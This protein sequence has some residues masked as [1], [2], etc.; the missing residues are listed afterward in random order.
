[1]K[2]WRGYLT[3][4]ILLA[5]T[6][7]LREFARAN[8]ALVDMIYPYVTRMM[9]MFLENWSSG[10]DYCLWQVLLVV[11]VVL[12]LAIAVLVVVFKWNP[13]QWGGWICA[14]AAA[15]VFL[16][17][18]LY[19]L[20][21]FS[22]PLS[23]DIR[24][25]ETDYAIAELEQAA[26]YY[27]DQANALALQVER[28]SKGDVVFADFGTLAQQAADGFDYLVYEESLSVFAGP[29]NPVKKLGWADRYTKQ[30]VTGVTVG[31]TG[32]AAVNPQVP[33]VLMPF[34]MCREMARR[35]SIVIPRDASFASLMAC[36]ANESVQFQY[37]GAL[38]SYRYC[39]L[40]LADL[41]QVTGAGVAKQVRAGES[42][43]VIHDL[44]VVSGFLGNK[45]GE[46]GDTCDLLTSWHIQEIVLP[47]LLEEEKVFNPMDKTQVDLSEHPNA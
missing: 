25:E 20:N 2:Y 3:A 38:L 6:W 21:E 7:G 42:N 10:L 18:A 19:G 22:G 8:S 13:I 39:M 36:K 11:G 40:A 12:I 26:I 45:P 1:M 41:D 46:D 31:L 30:G 24:L 14:A 34:A 47:S 29:M 32:E 35:M 16:N 28:D 44:N 27:R 4:G 5:C 15:V 23:Q 33:G 17:T 37:S 9:A 43:D